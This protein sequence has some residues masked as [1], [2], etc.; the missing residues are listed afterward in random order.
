[1]YHDIFENY[2]D[3]AAYAKQCAINH[4]KSMKIVRNGAGWQVLVPDVES[5]K[6]IRHSSQQETY[7]PRSVASGI[8]KPK[9]NISSFQSNTLYNKYL[10]EKKPSLSCNP[11]TV[12]ENS[13]AR[14]PKKNNDYST[15]KVAAESVV[16]KQ[17][18]HR[19]QQKIEERKKRKFLEDIRNKPT[20][21]KIEKSERIIKGAIML[22]Y[23]NFIK[24]KEAELKKGFLSEKSINLIYKK[25]QKYMPNEDAAKKIGSTDG[26]TTIGGHD[27]Y[28]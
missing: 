28:R 23:P 15:K 4:K 6:T 20:K 22:G 14:S 27:P 26:L 21:E 17:Q 24:A 9:K 16:K 2:A 1:M 25:Y 19:E 8:A 12:T 7:K 5:S 3:A 11:A 18:E 13:T 10:A